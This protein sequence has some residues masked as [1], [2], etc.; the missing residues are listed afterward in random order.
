MK[1]NVLIEKSKNNWAA[2]SNDDA[3]NGCIAV[4]GETRDDALANFRAALLDLSEFNTERGIPA[5]SVT[6]MEIHELVPI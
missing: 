4:T 1:I 3:L 2:S 6:E 5:S